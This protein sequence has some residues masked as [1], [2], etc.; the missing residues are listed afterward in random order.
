M[1]LNPAQAS[2]VRDALAKGIYSNLFDWIVERVNVSMKARAPTA[3]VIGVLDI[4]GFEIFDVSCARGEK[5]GNGA[6]KPFSSQQ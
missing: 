5:S 4:Y 3:H 1:P 6:D 2:S